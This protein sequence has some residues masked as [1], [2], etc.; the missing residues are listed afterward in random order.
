M[1]EAA[2]GLLAGIRGGI[3]R[4][5]LINLFC[6]LLS[7]P[8]IT[9]F[10]L[11]LNSY[12]N[13]TLQEG[14][15]DILPGIGYFAGILLQL[16][17]FLFYGLF[18]LSALLIGPLT[19]GLHAVAG[20]VVR[21]HEIHFSDCLKQAWQNA[22]QGIL[23]GLFS[24]VFIHLTLWNAFGG[25]W[26]ADPLMSIVLTAS[27]WVS[28]LLLLLFFLALPFVCQIAVS[29]QLPLQAVL[30]NALILARV[31]LGRGLLMLFGILAYWW[32]TVLAIPFASLV[33][34]P[35]LSLALTALIQA[36]V[37]VPLVEKHILEPARKK[38]GYS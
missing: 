32:L 8:V 7:L 22:F 18:I 4:L 19:L 31:Y 36:V 33:G 5:F 6:F 34:L 27:R 28:L 14:I 9:W 10:Y 30:K 29:I 12:V 13:A 23:L 16:P 15:V 17:A 2:S 3:H 20:E 25:M 37:S 11:L 38:T 26:S 21:G 24:V 35:L 1:K